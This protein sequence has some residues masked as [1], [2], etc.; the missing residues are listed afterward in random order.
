[1]SKDDLRNLSSDPQEIQKYYDGWAKKYDQDTRQMRY[2]APKRAADILAEY[3]ETAGLILDAGCGT[4]L[5]GEELQKQGFLNLYGVDISAESLSLAK[6]KNVYSELHQCDISAEPLPFPAN[7]FDV[8][9]SIGVL[10][11]IHPADHFLAQ[12][13]H[14]TKPNGY[15][16][17]TQRADHMK[18]RRFQNTLEAFET[19]GLWKVISISTPQPY[20]P[21]SPDMPDVDVHYILCRV[22]YAG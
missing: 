22:G 20:L 11:Y 4:G 7:Q 21:L 1:M 8:S 16:L 19:D 9:Q 6:K 2:S 13:I 14:V 12:L 5:C 3:V 15:I 17:L 18:S 10:T